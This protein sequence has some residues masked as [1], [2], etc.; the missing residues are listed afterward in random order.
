MQTSYFV[1]VMGKQLLADYEEYMSL[2]KQFAKE[3]EAQKK[4]GMRL[5]LLRQLIHLEGVTLPTSQ[6]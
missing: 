6:S 3:R 5:E 2:R 4:A 1:D